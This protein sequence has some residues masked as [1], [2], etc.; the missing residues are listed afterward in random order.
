M[1]KPCLSVHPPVSNLVSATILVVKFSRNS[2]LE[3]LTRS[4]SSSMFN[5]NRHTERHT[6]LKDKNEMLPVFSTFFKQFG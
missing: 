6:L 1:W 2:V 3:L 5:E 4:S